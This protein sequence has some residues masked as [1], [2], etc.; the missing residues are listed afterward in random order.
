MFEVNIKNHLGKEYTRPS[1]QLNHLYSV[2]IKCQKINFKDWVYT[3]QIMNWTPLLWL[4]A[5]EA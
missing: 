4:S 1:L 2:F 5:P 3:Q